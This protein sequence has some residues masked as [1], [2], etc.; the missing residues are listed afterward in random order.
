MKW[1]V[2]ADVLNAARRPTT[3]GDAR[4]KWDYQCFHCKGWFQG[5]EVQVDHI[6]ECGSIVDLA[7]LGQFAEGLFCEADNLQVLCKACHMVKTLA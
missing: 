3:S 5:K 7:N 2:K 4:R 6:V 1:P